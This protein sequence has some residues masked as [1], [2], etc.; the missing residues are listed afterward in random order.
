VFREY[1]KERH[2][3]SKAKAAIIRDVS[4]WPWC[5]LKDSTEVLG[6]GLGNEG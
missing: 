4:P 3:L 6:L 1:V 5:V 2:P